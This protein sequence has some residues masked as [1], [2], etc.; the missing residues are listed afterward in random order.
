MGRARALRGQVRE[1]WRARL[2][3]LEHDV[4]CAR[5]GV[6]QHT[7]WRWVREVGGMIPDLGESTGRYLSNAE[8]EEISR[9]LAA[10]HSQAEIARALGR[11]PGTISREITRNHTP[12][13]R[14]GRHGP[15]RPN[16]GPP[17][18]GRRVCASPREANERAYR[19]H[20][21]QAKAEARARRP[22]PTKFAGHPELV[23]EV[24]WRLKAHW[25]P[26]QITAE[27]RER[28]PDRPEMW[29][30]HETIYQELYVQGRGQLRREL[31]HCLRT[32]R[33][34]RRPRAFTERSSRSYISP[35]VMI[36]QRPAEAD[37]RAVP[38]HWEGDLILGAG[39]ASA[40]GTL[41]ERSTRF[42]ML[43]H[44]PERHDAETVRDAMIPAIGAL[45]AA[46]RRSLAWDQG[47]EMARHHEIRVAADLPIYFC[48]PHSPWQRGSN[49]NTNGLLRQY[50]PKGSD[51]SIHTA[52]DLAAVAAELNGRPRKTLDWRCPARAIDQLLSAPPTTGVATTP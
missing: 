5:A 51:L 27:L 35:E 6:S 34:L 42:V 24:Q 12:S 10:G 31:H 3:G 47:S 21:A 43:L 29:V 7:G 26:E 4:A 36:S 45:P 40:I 9:G 32:G 33:A 30:S 41:V 11:D 28:F 16:A 49:E 39:N 18:P 52:A 37:D 22:K 44:L 20:Q 25:S 38:G 50:F 46:L 17:R 1:F 23:T 15:P 19:A 8:R 2:E 48:D 13:L 14:P